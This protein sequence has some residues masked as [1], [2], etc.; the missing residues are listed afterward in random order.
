LKKNL[1]VWR[2]SSGVRKAR[3]VSKSGNGVKSL[4]LNKINVFGVETA[5]T[6]SGQRVYWRLTM[7]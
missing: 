6:M 3:N 2:L 4:I 7:K 1:V 5:A